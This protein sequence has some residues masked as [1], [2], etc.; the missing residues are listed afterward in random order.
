MFIL[1]YYLP[2]YLF[3]FSIPLWKHV[4]ILT[5][6][7]YVFTF[8]RLANSLIYL[9]KLL[10]MNW[11]TNSFFRS[12]LLH[13]HIHLCTRHLAKIP[14]MTWKN[15]PGVSDKWSNMTLS[16]AGSAWWS[17]HH[18]DDWRDSH[19]GRCRWRWW[20]WCHGCCEYLEA[21]VGARGHADYWFLSCKKGAG[22]TNREEQICF[23]SHA[24]WQD[25]FPKLTSIDKDKVI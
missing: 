16:V 18:S 2:I 9:S 11:L 5:V 1:L 20:W 12:H 24:N 19:F 25:I 10:L 7:R 3:V 23:F 15:L 14:A 13:A 8:C 21:R 4:P 22:V 6:C 17:Q